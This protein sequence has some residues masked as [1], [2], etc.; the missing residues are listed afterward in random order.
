MHYLRS[1]L[2]LTKNY[3]LQITNIFC[4]EGGTRTHTLAYTSLSRARLPFRHF[5]N[6]KRTS[7]KLMFLFNLQNEF[8]QIF[9]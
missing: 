9:L 5:G 1:I 3:N 8:I 4:T 6:I 2:T 7:A